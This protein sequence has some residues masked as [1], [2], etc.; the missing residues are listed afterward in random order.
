MSNYSCRKCLALVNSVRLV[1]S[2][3][4]RWVGDDGCMRE[5]GNLYKTLL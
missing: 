4:L 5:T 3:R 2:G 1:K